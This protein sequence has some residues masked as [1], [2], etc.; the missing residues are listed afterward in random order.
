LYTIEGVTEQGCRAFMTGSAYLY[1]SPLIAVNAMATLSNGALIGEIDVVDN[2]ILL[3][4]IDSLNEPGK[5]IYFKLDTSWTYMDDNNVAQ[6]YSTVGDVS[7]NNEGKLE[8]RKLPSFYGRDSVRYIIYN[9]THPERIDTATVFI[10]V[11][12]I[13]LGNGET[14]LIPNAFSPNGDNI[15]DKF[16]I[17]GIEDKQESKLEVFNRWGTL[18]Y[19]SRGQNYENDWDGKST[20]SSMVSAGEDL[21]NGTYFYVF[22]VKV[23]REGNVI[24]KEYSGYI[25]LRR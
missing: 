15:N 23:N 2:D 19:R 17:T 21:P 6:K 9:T 5:N 12:N 14:F 11:G 7:I 8:Y 1:Q 4:G 22:S 3:E 25:E 18:V 24:E 13:D 10:F 20:E 16:V